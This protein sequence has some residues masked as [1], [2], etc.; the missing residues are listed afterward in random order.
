MLT[1]GVNWLA[2][3][4]CVLANMIIGAVWYGVFANPWMAGIGKT[5]EEIEQNQNMQPYAVAV[6]NSFLMAFV[7]A[8][9][10][11]WAGISGLINGLFVGL[12]MW[13]G[14]TGFTMGAN[15]AFEGRSLNLWAINSGTYLVGLLVMGAIL[16]AWQ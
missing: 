12:L 16:G 4:V 10:L 1:F 15:H 3:V 8:N 2:I 13:L 5:R 6:L 7:L 14:F 11:S 9:V